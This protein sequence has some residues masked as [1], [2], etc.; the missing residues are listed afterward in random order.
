MGTTIGKTVMVEDGS[1]SR[2]EPFL[3]TGSMAAAGLFRYAEA[4]PNRRAHRYPRAR[5]VGFA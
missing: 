2:S 4:L 3:F 5:R 1:D